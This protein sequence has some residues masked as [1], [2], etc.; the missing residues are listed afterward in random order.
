M[1]ATPQPN[2]SGSTEDIFAK[3]DPPKRTTRR[4][5]PAKSAAPVP[6]VPSALPGRHHYSILI[7]VVGVVVVAGL[8]GLGWWLQEQRQRSA[9]EDTNQVVT[10]FATNQN[11][12]RGSTNTTNAGPVISVNRNVEELPADADHDGLSDAEEKT[13][14]S[15][16]ASVDSDQDGLT[17]LLEVKLY[18]SDPTGLDTDGDGNSDK[19]EVDAGYDPAGPGR[20][21]DISDAVNQ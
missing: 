11:T 12:N 2:K 5:A 13:I 15:N 16:P 20:L 9:A 7:V 21:F 18:H 3:V 14:G 19:E 6:V 1:P 4:A 17:D 10:N 8:V